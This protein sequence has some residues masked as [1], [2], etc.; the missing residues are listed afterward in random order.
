[1]RQIITKQDD[2]FY[3]MGEELSDEEVL[4]MLNDYD[5]AVHTRTLNEREQL[6]KERAVN[7]HLVRENRLLVHKIIHF[8]HKGAII[9]E[10]E[11][12]KELVEIDDDII[13]ELQKT[14]LENEELKKE[15]YFLKH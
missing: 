1:M 11:I 3:R 4:R 9:N 12:A 15:L 10:D 8:I 5:Y 7:R 13:G 6:I 14:Q 2:K